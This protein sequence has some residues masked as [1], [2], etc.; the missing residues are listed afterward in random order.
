MEDPLHWQWE[1]HNGGGGWSMAV[2]ILLL[3]GSTYLNLSTVIITCE[4]ILG[5]LR[6]QIMTYP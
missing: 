3:H 2:S 6:K 4:T 5:S 1:W